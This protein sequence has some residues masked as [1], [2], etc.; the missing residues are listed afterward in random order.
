M[1]P[2]T[3]ALLGGVLILASLGAAFGQGSD[4]AA[5]GAASTTTGTQSTLEPQQQP[6][7]PTQLQAETQAQTEARAEASA[8]PAAALKAVRDRAKGA[9]SKARDTVEKKLAEI[10][11]EI[12]AEASAKGDAVVADRVAAEFGMTSEALSAEQSSLNTGWGD[13]VISHTLLANAKTPLTA[14]HLYS[15]HRSGYGWGQIAYGLNLRLGEVAAAVKTEGGVATGFA[16]A[17]GK[18][19]MIHSGTRVGAGTKT[20]AGAG[21]TTVGAS[22]G[23]GVGV[24]LGK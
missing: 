8:D 4:P 21:K 15:L 9:P 14:E 18:A 22:S 13:L 24:K 16:K 6:A 3:G 23:I 10:S 5:S 17:D 1:K 11:T 7:P 2:I 19:A 12:D 20:T